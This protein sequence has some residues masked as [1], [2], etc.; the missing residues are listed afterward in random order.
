MDKK[1]SE[2]YS[3]RTEE[4]LWHY[5]QILDDVMSAKEV[6]AKLKMSVPNFYARISGIRKR[7]AKEGFEVPY[8]GRPKG[9]DIE[10]ITKLF[11]QQPE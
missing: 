5:K 3:S 1:K 4:L 11:P 7:M 9:L 10:A 8:K 2:Q 6:A